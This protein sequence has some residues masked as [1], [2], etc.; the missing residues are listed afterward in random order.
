MCEEERRSHIITS[1][2]GW[3]AISKVFGMT[4]RSAVRR[5]ER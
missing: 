1:E 5:A 3:I 4:E 2:V